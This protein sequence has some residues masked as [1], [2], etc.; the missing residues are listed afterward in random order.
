MRTWMAFSR[1]WRVAAH[2]VPATTEPPLLAASSK[3]ELRVSVL[4]AAHRREAVPVHIPSLLALCTNLLHRTGPT[5]ATQLM[6]EQRDACV[7]TIACDSYCILPIKL[8]AEL[9]ARANDYITWYCD[10]ARVDL[11]AMRL[12][13]IF[14]LLVNSTFYH[15]FNLVELDP[16]FHEMMTFRPAL[17]LCYDCFGPMFHLGQEKVRCALVVCSIMDCACM[18]SCTRSVMCML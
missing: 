9:I 10:A 17:Q 1:L 11:T 7:A 12:G 15:Q 18:T 4:L 14:K 5:G 3:E 6:D 16:V 8:P 2:L 13:G